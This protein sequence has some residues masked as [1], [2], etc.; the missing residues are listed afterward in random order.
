MNKQLCVVVIMTVLASASVVA[1]TII[2]PMESQRAWTGQRVGVTD[3]TIEYSRPSVKGREVWGSLVPYNKVWRAGANENTTFTTSHA[4]KIEGQPLAAGKYGVHM[5]PTEGTWTIIFNKESNGWGSYFYNQVDDA[6]RVTVTP[7]PAQHED[8]LTY[9]ITDVTDDK[10]VVSLRWDKVDVRFNV[11]AD[12][13]DAVVAHMKS[14]LSSLHGFNP[15]MYT[16]AAS[17]A[18]QH[19]LDQ[20]QGKAWAERAFR[21]KPSFTNAMLVADYED[22]SGNAAKAKEYREKGQTKATNEELNLYGY[23]LLGEK[24]ISEAIAVFTENTKRNPD[25]ANTWDSLGEAYATNGDKAK[26]RDSFKKSLSKNPSPETKAN[27][28]MWL[29]KLE[30]M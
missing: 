17:Y 18:M 13:K 10:C 20:V 19:N 28:E 8:L 16:S 15:D 29:K 14:Q 26:A 2:T 22:A 11:T 7:K 12:I 5:I 4:V 1:Q 6:L 21:T 27:S 23:R 30:K 25:D 3:I 24:K 9:A